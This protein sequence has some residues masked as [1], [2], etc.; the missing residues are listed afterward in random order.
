[1]RTSSVLSSLK[2]ALIA[3]VLIVT[4]AATAGAAPTGVRS[5]DRRQG[6]RGE[7][8]IERVVKVIKR[9]LGVTTQGET[10]TLPNPT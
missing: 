7:T 3:S 8:A 6:I 1:M 10:L 5:Y 9:F 4:L 2:S